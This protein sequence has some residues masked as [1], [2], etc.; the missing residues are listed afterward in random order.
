[1]TVPNVTPGCKI[2]CMNYAKC[3][4]QRRKVAFD[5][6][7]PC[8]RRQLAE[9]NNPEWA[10][11]RCLCGCGDIP[12]PGSKFVPSHTNRVMT[13][14]HRARLSAKS[15]GRPMHPNA[16]K[17][18]LKWHIGRPMNDIQRKA[19][20]KANTGRIQSEETKAKKSAALKG[21]KPST[22]T[23]RAVAE[24][25]RHREWTHEKR[26]QHWN[27][28]GGVGKR[29]RPLHW[30]AISEKI[31]ERD[32]GECMHCHGSSLPKNNKKLDVHHIDGNVHNNE[33]R[34]LITLC[35]KC[36]GSAHRYLFISAPLLRDILS[37]CYGYSYIDRL[38]A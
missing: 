25:N 34:N 10:N 11:V 32:A 20:L 36:H 4:P 30:Y 27:W 13:E 18:L 37:D 26:S 14:T 8:Y 35:Y 7:G 21:R 6:C 5:L 15:R 38:A 29:S 19:L 12:Y 33:N 23:R 2:D 3:H 31:R 24:A 28:K 16:K 1:M 17:A 9:R 22:N